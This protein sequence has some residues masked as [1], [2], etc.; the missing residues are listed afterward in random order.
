MT[1]RE[2]QTL[3]FEAADVQTAMTEANHAG[4]TPT[5]THL[6]LI[7]CVNTG[8]ELASTP[9]GFTT[10]PPALGFF[11]AYIHTLRSQGDLP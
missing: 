2:H 8:V 9:T 5:M 4:F 1:D 6:F 10:I 11:R 3:T 7:V